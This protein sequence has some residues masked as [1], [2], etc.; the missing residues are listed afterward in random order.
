MTSM[1]LKSVYFT[2]VAITVKL[3]DIEMDKT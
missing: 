1:N 3:I 2:H